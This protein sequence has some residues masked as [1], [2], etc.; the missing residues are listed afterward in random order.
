MITCFIGTQ[1]TEGLFV[2]FIFLIIIIIS[3]YQI[4][5]VLY[6]DNIFRY[7]KKL[8]NVYK[9]NSCYIVFYFILHF[10][11]IFNIFKDI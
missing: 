5:K 9:N 8:K 10:P 2:Y 1:K 3:F 7:D 6:I 11:S 4:I